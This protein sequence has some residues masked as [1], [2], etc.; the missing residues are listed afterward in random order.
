M[1]KRFSLL[2]IALVFAG[3]V[4]AEAP[5]AHAQLQQGE[6]MTISPASSK[7]TVDAGKVVEGKITV[8][9]DGTE[10]YEFVLYAR[11]YSIVDNQ[12]DSPNFTQVTPATDVY[13]WLSFP[14]TKYRIE[15]G[16]TITADYTMRVPADAAP[17][18]HYG[19]IF[20]ETQ[21]TGEQPTGSMILRKKR[22]GSV[23]YVT[24][25]GQYKVAGQEKDWSIPFWQPLPPLKTSLSAKNEGNT[26]FTNT[27]RLVVKDI[28][29]TTKYDVKKEFQVLPGTTRTMDLEWAEALWFGFYK[30]ETYQEFLDKSYKHEGYVLM[31]PRF[32]PFLLVV[33][34]GGG[35]AYAYLRRRK[36]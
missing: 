5:A 11:P 19:V 16:Q 12:Y 28:F 35:I 14:K 3:T 27:T 20:A 33:M 36:K 8:V 31:M 13:K 34:I 24:V 29:G 23:M 10:P 18:G 6:S 9:N 2:A 30:V 26:D 22:A 4:F 25:N 21:P 7:L 1:R 15:A 32:I 17:G